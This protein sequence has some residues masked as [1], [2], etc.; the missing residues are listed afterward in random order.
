MND[1]DSSF[2]PDGR[3]LVTYTIKKD[4]ALTIIA[5]LKDT[6]AW[7]SGLK[8]GDKL[9]IVAPGSYISEDDLQQSVKNLTQLG[10]ET[11]YSKKVLLQT[12]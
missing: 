11:T 6:P 4:D 1:S 7:K 10:F 8:A 5:P 2:I 9:A 12:G 3:E